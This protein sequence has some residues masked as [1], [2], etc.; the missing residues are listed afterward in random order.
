MFR[1][2]GYVEKIGSGLIAIFDAYEKQ[3]LADPQMVEGE[4]YIKCILPRIEKQRGA[5][6]DDQQ[7]LALFDIHPEI[8]VDQVQSALSISRATAT[9]RLSRLIHHGKVI[10]IGKTRSTRFRRS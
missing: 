10:R 8:T 2:A 5:M 9:R 7:I 4:N 6:D 1:E 3:N